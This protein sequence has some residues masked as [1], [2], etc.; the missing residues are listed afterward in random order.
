MMPQFG[1][2]REYRKAQNNRRQGLR[3]MINQTKG[4]PVKCALK[5]GG[6]EECR[7][8]YS[9][10]NMCVTIGQRYATGESKHG[11]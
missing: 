11:M 10:R 3:P 7:E 6:G 8:E 9:S 2:R 5:G 1:R 4:N